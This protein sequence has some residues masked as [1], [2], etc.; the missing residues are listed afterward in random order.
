[1]DFSIENV[2]ERWA[3]F[4]K[5]VGLVMPE[6]WLA[7][8][9]CAVI[10]VPFIRRRDVRLPIYAALGTLLLALVALARKSV[11]LDV[12]GADNK[13]ITESVSTMA[14]ST[15]V[16]HDMLVIDH[17]SQF[18]KLLLIL[19]TALI[20]AQWWLLKRE[21][22]SDLD[23]PDFFCLLLGATFGMAL[24]ASAN[25]LLMIVIAIEAASL[26][27][28][29]LAGYRKHTRRGTEASL[30]YVIFGAASSA[31]MIY[32][33]SLIYGTTGTLSLPGVAHA[34]A[35]GGMTPLLAIGLIA[36]FAGLAFKL[37][38]VP[39]HFW[40]PDV[41]Q[42]APM[43]V[44]TFLS[45]A[46]K[47]AAVVLLVRI[48]HAFGVARLNLDGATGEGLFMGICVGVAILGGVTATWGNLLAFH[49]NNMK[50]ML[51]YSS[52]AHAGYMIMAC[53]ALIFPDRTGGDVSGAILFYLL[54]YMFMNLG[55]FTIVGLIAERTGSEDI[56][57]YTGLIKRSPAL[58]GLLIL[59]LLSLFGMPGLGGFLGK[60]YLMKGMGGL[61]DGALVVIAVL[62][63]NTLISL[64]F[65]MRPVFYMVFAKD[66]ED[67][68]S[69]A[70]GA[71]QAILIACAAAVVWTGLGGG[72]AMTYGFAE[73]RS[74]E[75]EAVAP[76]AP[77]QP[78][79]ATTLQ[80]V[81][82]NETDA[83]ATLA[84]PTPIKREL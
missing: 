77:V 64:Y 45:V 39:M 68:P 1:M 31:I 70:L 55:A 58:A 61:G 63:I 16:F 41:F 36:M 12:I 56:R 11:T 25:N 46:S 42:G 40:C 57:A 2:G 47:G 19:F 24:M 5:E 49:Q 50:R 73:L 33:M 65:Y 29:A 76:I 51:A 23:A 8:G 9:M 26:P 79:P 69:F 75:K 72:S 14:M 78:V 71:G 22:G 21:R 30:K 59:F 10:L 84:T 48:V 83:G 81:K 66:E 43:P 80:P 3:A 44:T 37:S 62:L 18:F 34:A 6:V 38:A 17:F 52:I 13:L 74:P 35:T 27:S 28:F 7:V 60:I 4:W 67:R 53:A 32:G 54:V 82:P 15:T 20:I